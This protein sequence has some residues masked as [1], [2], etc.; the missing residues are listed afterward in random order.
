[1]SNFNFQNTTVYYEI[2]GQGAPLLF[3]HGWGTD[4]TSFHQLKQHFSANY[5][6]ISVDFP[7]FGKSPEPL[8]AWTL[9]QYISMVNA[10]IKQLELPSF[11][12]I[13]HSFGCRV[14]TGIKGANKLVLIGAAGIKPKRRFSYYIKIFGY[15]LLKFLHHIPLFRSLLQRP[16]DAYRTLYASSDYQQASPIMK[17]TLSK[18]VNHDLSAIYHTIETPTLLIFGTNDTE[19]PVRDGR[20]ME[21]EMK[22]AALIEIEGAGHYVFLEK[23]F[24][25]SLIIDSFL[26]EGGMYE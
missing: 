25:T 21:H 7:G 10:L 1:M 26:S 23:P 11:S 5:Q 3:L 6:L 9:S 18:V 2:E 20:I 13:G 16:L 22:N 24:E 15:K 4:S 19:T 12:L 8:E 17:Q 14:A